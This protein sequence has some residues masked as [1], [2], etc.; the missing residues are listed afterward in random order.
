[1]NSNPIGNPFV[2][3]PRVLE[4]YSRLA[5]D[6]ASQYIEVP[7]S[8]RVVVVPAGQSKFRSVP[9]IMVRFLG[10]H[11]KLDHG[12]L[13]GAQGKNFHALRRLLQEFGSHFKHEVGLDIVDPGGAWM[14]GKPYE[15]D[16]EWDEEKDEAFRLRLEN[17][18][19]RV[20]GYPVPVRVIS[21]YGI[22]HLVIETGVIEPEL[23]GAFQ[24][25]WQAMGRNCG[26]KVKLTSEAP[27]EMK[28]AV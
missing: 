19:E 24:V 13:I 11:S 12:K 15:E 17:I 1:M 9:L 25:L 28:Q 14:N 20:F 2:L 26:R 16:P 4:S 6:I 3:D 10:Q 8:L 22:T 5:Y 21:F 18:S 27:K 7:D 23:L